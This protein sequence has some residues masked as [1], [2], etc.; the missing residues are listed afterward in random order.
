MPKPIFGLNSDAR[1]HLS[2]LDRDVKCAQHTSMRTP[3]SCMRSTRIEPKVSSGSSFAAS[4][5]FEISTILFTT[6]A[7]PRSGLSLTVLCTLSTATV[8]ASTKSL[9]P[10][11]CRHETVLRQQC[12]AAAMGAYRVK[13]TCKVLHPWCKPH[14][15][16]WC[17]AAVHLL[18]VKKHFSYLF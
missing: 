11:P 2:M 7:L 14:T 4:R 16:A 13:Q 3:L 5:K 12:C 17:R 10:D 18:F 6:L 15:A 1:G 9:E 8:K